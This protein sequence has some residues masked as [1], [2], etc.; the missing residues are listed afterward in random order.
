MTHDVRGR[1]VER[2]PTQGLAADCL[3]PQGKRPAGMQPPLEFPS[4]RANVTRPIDGIDRLGAKTKQVLVSGFGERD[5]QRA[6]SPLGARRGLGYDLAERIG[7]RNVDETVLET[8]RDL[9]YDGVIGRR[10]ADAP[11]LAVEHQR[12]TLRVE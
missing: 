10:S 11:D 6:A 2:R 5:E 1:N 9:R 12:Q 7:C 3:L 8:V 4:R